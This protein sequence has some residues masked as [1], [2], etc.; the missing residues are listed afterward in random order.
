MP[1]EK[2]PWVICPTDFI[3]EPPRFILPC[4]I[5]F[6]FAYLAVIVNSIGSI[7]GI[8]EIVGKDQ[9]KKRVDRGIGFTGIGGVL[10]GLMGSIGT[11]SY[12]I[13]PGVV[14][15]SRVGTR[16]ALTFCGV[17]LIL[18]SFIPKIGALFAVIPSA[19]IGAVLCVAMGSQ[20]GAGI[21]VIS[22]KG[23]MKTRDY[24]VVGIPTLLGT[25]TSF[26]PKGIYAPL[27]SFLSA[28]LANGVVLGIISVLIMEHLLLRER[29]S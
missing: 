11:V 1:L 18:L 4:I 23:S 27:P 25:M 12:S 17:I 20:I 24:L 28:I 13:S 3:I 5:T 29:S 6:L 16:F 7:H 21:A 10:A 22:K 26:L 14:L 15:V 2:S 19:V 8:S 9:I